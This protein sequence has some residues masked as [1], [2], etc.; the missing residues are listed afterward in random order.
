[1]PGQQA[2]LGLYPSPSVDVGLGPGQQAR[3]SEP[4]EGGT[5]G[6]ILDARGRPFTVPTDPMERIMRIRQWHQALGLEA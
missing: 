2:L 3:A 6:L 5:L 1:M 4:V